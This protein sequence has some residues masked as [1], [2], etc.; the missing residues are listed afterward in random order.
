[1]RVIMRQWMTILGIAFTFC[2]N[3]VAAQEYIYVNESYSGDLFSSV[4]CIV[5]LLLYHEMGYCAG[6][7]VDFQKNGHFYEPSR[8]SNWWEY[9]FE[10][11][12]VGNPDDG[13]P[14]P[15][16][17]S[18]AYE[19]TQEIVDACKPQRFNKIIKKHIRVKPAIRQKMQHYF[20]Q[21]FKGQ[22]M[23][24]VHFIKN[25]RITYDNISQA[26]HRYVKEKKIRDYRLFVS[27]ED[28]G[29]LDFMRMLFTDRV[30]FLPGVRSK[31]KKSAQVTTPYAQGEREVLEWLLL[32]RSEIM[33]HTHST[34]SFWVKC[35]NLSLP[36]IT[37][38]TD[39]R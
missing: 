11:I 26:I 20:A 22:T 24:G 33:I 1:M 3:P 29:F 15:C 34:L 23:I 35:Q 5:R 8:G 27:T 16:G 19:A 2:L 10:P 9:Y 4:N 18:R 28:Q 17:E 13:L 37:I 25:R 32:A 14:I 31:G 36:T 21:N 7:E 39:K 12:Q 30:R 38:E 6:I